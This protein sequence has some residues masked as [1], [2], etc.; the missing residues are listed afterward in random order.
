MLAVHD[1]VVV[2]GLSKRPELNGINGRVTSLN[3]GANSD[4]IAV[5]L[6][7]GSGREDDRID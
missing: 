1:R 7:Q 2:R 4:R 6:D 5:Q 3:A